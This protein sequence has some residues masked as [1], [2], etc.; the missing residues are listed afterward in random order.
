MRCVLLSVPV[1]VACA[2]AHEP[3]T[4]EPKLC[5]ARCYVADGKMRAD[6][7]GCSA[8][9]PKPETEPQSEPQSEPEPQLREPEL[10]Q[11]TPDAQTVVVEP[12]VAE[13]VA[14]EPAAVE[15]VAVEPVAADHIVHLSVLGFVSSAACLYWKH[16]AELRQQ[17]AHDAKLAQD[18]AEEQR[19]QERHTMERARHEAEQRRQDELLELEWCRVGCEQ[20]NEQPE[21]FAVAGPGRALGRPTL[22]HRMQI[23]PV[24]AYTPTRGGRIVSQGEANCHSMV[25]KNRQP[26]PFW[27]RGT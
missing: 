19:R 23:K 7:K 26:H 9:L 22:P 13:L 27:L 18:Q 25:G 21:P 15:P 11:M 17:Q 12:I 3:P 10:K 14:A 2:G 8:C 1:L 5:N 16:C 4:R 20:A 24:R 6:M